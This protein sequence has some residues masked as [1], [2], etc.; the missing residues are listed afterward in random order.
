MKTRTILRVSYRGTLKILDPGHHYELDALDTD[1]KQTLLFVKR[2]GHNYPGNVGTH[3]GVLTQ[4]VLRVLIDRCEYMNAQGRCAETDFI[5]ANLRNA[6]MMFEVRA[7]RCRG[8]SIDLKD[9]LIEKEPTCAVCGHI[10]CDFTRH[11]GRPH[12]SDSKSTEE[13]E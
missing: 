12:W 4:E 1:E 7:A 11:D 3:P 10:Q 5:L 6:L 9:D 8:T 13:V 2:E